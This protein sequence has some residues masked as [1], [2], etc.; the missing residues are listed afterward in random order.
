[1]NHD[2]T[3]ARARFI[4]QSVEVCQ[5]FSF[6]SPVEIIRAL[7]VYCS[8]HYGSM[9]W[10]LG[11]EAATQYCNAWSTAIKLAWQCP[12]ATRSYLLQ[13]VLACGSTSAQIAIRSRY[14]K[15]CLGLHSSSSR[16]VAVLFHFLARDIRSTTGNN[17]RILRE[18]ADVN[19]WTDST[20]SVRAKLAESETVEVAEIDKWR[21]RYLGILLEQRQQWHYMGE[22]EEVEKVQKLIDSLCVN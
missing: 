12:R 10:E 4:D 9:L 16:E 11:G 2:A 17:L 5:V 20:A 7:Q 8:S 21:V 15:F 3:I 22:E 13:Q 1:M 14:T 19:I 18:E 6:A